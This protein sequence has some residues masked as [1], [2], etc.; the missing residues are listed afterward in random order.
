MSRPLTR[1]VWA[2]LALA[3]TLALAA[4]GS[5]SSSSPSS[6]GNPTAG[7]N[8]G[9]QSGGDPLAGKKGGDISVLAESDVDSPDPGITYEQF[10]FAVTLATQRP[11]YSFGPPKYA[12]MLPDLADGQPKVSADKKTVTVKIKPNIKYSAPV[13]RAVKSADVKYAIE[14]GFGNTV[15]NGYV[16]AYFSS[17]EGA[18][19]GFKTG[20]KPIPGIQTPDDQTIVFH[21]TKP[22][23]GFFV[24]ALT[25]PITAPVPKEYAAKYDKETPSSYQDHMVFT[26]PYMYQNDGKGKI[27][28]HSAG[29]S[30]DL[31]R[32]P[33][34]DPKTDYRKAYVNSYHIDEGVQD[35]TS[36]SQKILKGSGLI[37][38]NLVPSAPILKSVSQGA[39]GADKTQLAF[40]PAAGVRYMSMNTTVK[41]FDN[42]NLRKAVIA[43][44]DRDSLRLSRGGPILGPV[45]THIIQPQFPG[46]EEGGGL[47]G[48]ED[49]LTKTAGDK[50]VAMKYWKAAGYPS[51][52]YTGKETLLFVGE[53]SGVPAQTAQNAAQQLRTMGFKLNVK[54]VPHD[55]MYQKFCN[56]PSAK[57]AFCPNTGFAK[58][59]QDPQT[60]L[61]PTFN[62]AS[63]APAGNSNWPQLDD[64]KINAAMDK[65]KTVVGV[66]A[67]GKAWGAVDKMVMAKGP[68]VPWIWDNTPLV[69]SKN[70][71][72]IP[73][74]FT[75]SWD[76]SFTYLK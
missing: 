33:N 8:V 71:V 37:G 7:V 70:V 54:L 13:N 28:G 17:I 51:G 39:G 52:K 16:P 11:L 60:L 46:F 76:F 62:G 43:S 9:G 27:T 4:C 63:I 57:V 58:D 21:L 68:V 29:K 55:I 10:S 19:A 22:Y 41:P 35:P 45:A 12:T 23:A 65:A 36:G 14:R 26:G 40:S 59:F 74:Q 44:F 31:V 49:F 24:G 2:A 6:K 48:T 66:D 1:V 67:R 38:G 20:P 34:W 25:L 5:S 72:S 18:P 15:S 47:K 53:N 42:E 3:M 73:N 50:A 64:P 56:V 69:R 75:N 30:I 32:N 61:D